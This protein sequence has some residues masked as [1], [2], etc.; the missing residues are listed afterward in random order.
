MSQYEESVVSFGN[1]IVMTCSWAYP[2][3]RSGSLKCQQKGKILVM[4]NLL[5]GVEGKVDQP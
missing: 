4:G 3:F 5:N 2:L 1:F